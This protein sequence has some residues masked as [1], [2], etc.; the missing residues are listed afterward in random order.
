M[1]TSK[2]R[3]VVKKQERPVDEEKMAL[4]KKCLHV[5]KKYKRAK[6]RMWQYRARNELFFLMYQRM[7]RWAYLFF[8][9]RLI[10]LTEDERRSLVWQAFEEV[11][12]K[13]VTEKSKQPAK[14]FF[15]NFRYL[16]SYRL[17][18]YKN[19]WLRQQRLKA[20]G[21]DPDSIAQEEGDRD[22]YM[23][24]MEFRKG[25]K[26]P[27]VSEQFEKMI[28]GEYEKFDGNVY[29]WGKQRQAIK[30]LREIVAYLLDYHKWGKKET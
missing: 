6:N 18:A 17:I 24:L 2:K 16:F 4:A 1:R 14:S 15:T 22:S 13:W 3:K 20:E 21:V 5:I 7:D 8:T 19:L 27:E 26:D 23:D 30:V 29:K 11:L 10:T 12:S 25:I 28:R 9:T